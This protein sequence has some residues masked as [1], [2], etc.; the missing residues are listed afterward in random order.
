[1]SKKKGIRTTKYRRRTGG[2]RQIRLRKKLTILHVPA[3][4][5]VIACGSSLVVAATYVSLRA[6]SFCFGA[7]VSTFRFELSFQ[8]FLQFE[9]FG[10]KAPLRP[11]FNFNR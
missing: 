4:G 6:C 7:C 9:G 10:V 8:S 11:Q 1:M 5:K 3:A 2:N